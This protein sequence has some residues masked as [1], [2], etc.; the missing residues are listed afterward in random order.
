MLGL[1]ANWAGVLSRF[2]PGLL[3]T[4]VVLCVLPLLLWLG[5]WQLE[6]AAFK[7]AQYTQLKARQQQPPLASTQLLT[8]AEP[9]FSS[10]ALSGHF[11]AQHYY[12][13]DNRTR[14]GLA[15]VELLQA[16]WD[17][18]SARWWLINRGWLRV[19]DRTQPPSFAT[20]QGRVALNAWVYVPQGQPLLLKAQA[21]QPALHSFLNVAEPEAIWAAL[22]RTGYRYELR[23]NDGPYALR[24]DWPQQIPSAHK[25]TGYAVQ[26]FALAAA[27]VAL[28]IYFGFQHTRHSSY[29]HR[30]GRT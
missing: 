26:W 30:L 5:L 19:S 13:L 28:F 21:A 4:L 3:P 24:T 6:R 1:S 14:D 22:G 10:V 29:E 25:H 17:A 16:F 7:Q 20:P 2:R 23:L 11:D 9:S 27:L 15:G 12:F 8:R 18:P